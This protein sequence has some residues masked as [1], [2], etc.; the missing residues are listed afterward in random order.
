MKFYS[1]PEETPYIGYPTIKYFSSL[2][3]IG[4][5]LAKA[6][7][8]CFFLKKEEKPEID[9][10]NLVFIGV[11]GSL[12]GYAVYNNLKNH[13]AFSV[14]SIHITKEGEVTHRSPLEVSNVDTYRNKKQTSFNVFVDDL[15]DSGETF[16]RALD[17]LYPLNLDM[18]A[19]DHA[20]LV[21]DFELMLD[22]TS[23]SFITR[24]LK[25]GHSYTWG[26]KDIEKEDIINP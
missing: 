16:K 6:I 9:H 17:M 10:I 13:T 4:E 19:C 12:I 25:D 3:K 7:S 20:S 14:H 2:P 5:I 26:G 18:I 8:T 15:I 1:L 22:S 23:I 21:T 24:T 11:S